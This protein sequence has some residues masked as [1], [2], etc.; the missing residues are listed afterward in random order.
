VLEEKDFERV[1]GTNLVKSDFRLLAAT[2]HNL[3]NMLA[4]NRFRTDLFYRLNVITLQVPP[5]RERQEDILPLAVHLLKQIAHDCGVP[6]VEITAE[7]QDVLL[8]YDWPGNI[9]ELSN[10]LERAVH[11]AESDRIKLSDLPRYL[12]QKN[13]RP[14]RATLEPLKRIQ[15]TAE[16]DA[17]RRALEAA[18]FNKA[19]A[20]QMLGIHRSLF[21]KK[22][23]KYGI[24]L[25]SE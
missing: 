13:K 17:L 19:R 20:A 5:L 23:K 15:H 22:L 2:N 16:K 21:Y 1:G 10:V 25:Q 4:E 18:G 12:L 8:G 3:E 7:A 11:Y 24:P 9:R 14:H 6:H